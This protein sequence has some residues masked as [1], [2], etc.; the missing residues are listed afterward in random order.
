MRGKLGTLTLADVN[1]A[2]RKHLSGTDLTVVV[3]TKDAKGLAETLLSDAPSAITY[4]APKPPELLD[5]D[6]R[7]GAL[8]LGLRP[9]AVTITPVAEVFGR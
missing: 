2:V 8:K 5:E 1:A 6:K 4:D 9:D 7:I 3:I